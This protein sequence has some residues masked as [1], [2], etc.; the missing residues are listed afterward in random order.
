MYSGTCQRVSSALMIP[1]V[2]QSMEPDQKQLVLLHEVYH[3]VSYPDQTQSLYMGVQ[4]C[5]SA[6]LCG[7]LSHCEVRY[8]RNTIPDLQ[9]DIKIRL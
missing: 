7:Y 6:L 5:C 4:V 8:M 3:G 9:G 1:R 2:F